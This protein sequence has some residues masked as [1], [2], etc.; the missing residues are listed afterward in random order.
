MDSDHR[1]TQLYPQHRPNLKLDE[2]YRLETPN[3]DAPLV[4]TNFITSMDG[5][6]AIDHP[7]TGKRG[8][9]KFITNPRDWRLYQL[10]AAQ[11]DVLLVSARYIRELSKGDAQDSLPV[12]QADEFHDLRAWRLERG[13]SPQPA[14]VI[15]S[16]S[17][18]IPLA[19]V[20]D[21]FNREVYVATGK[22]SPDSKLDTGRAKILHAGPGTQ[23]EGD[24][25]IKKLQA[26]GFRN[27]YSIAGPGVLE[28]L[29]RD[30]VLDRIYLTQVHRIIGGDEY[31]T[32]FEGKLLNPPAN[33]RLHSLYFDDGLGDDCDQFFSVYD[34]VK[35]R[36]D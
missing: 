19:R 22:Q 8:V 24:E 20:C 16:A 35:R 5:R 32:F 7:V 14:V 6:I 27:I 15:L 1:L 29:L 26:E 11:A 28:T 3:T 10:L 30:D 21:I 12:S 18:D 36:R 13:M 23:V 33:F 9:P 2:L 4:Y 17:L 31:D 34:A 25:L